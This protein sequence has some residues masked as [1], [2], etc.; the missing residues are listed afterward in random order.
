MINGI[1]GI[2]INL[3]LDQILPLSPPVIKKKKACQKDQ[4]A[5]RSM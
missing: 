3:L 2:W 4:Q 5:Y 1:T